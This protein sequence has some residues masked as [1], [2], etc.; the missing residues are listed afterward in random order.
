MTVRV[1]R[2]FEFPV[3]PERVWEFIADPELRAR[4]ISVV[5][6]FELDDE[7]GKRATWY[8]ELPIPL[9]N[10]TVPVQT[11]D[12]ERREPEF[13]KF[14]GR[15]R[16]MKVTGEHEIVPTEEGC[17]LTN[18][19]VVDGKLPGVERYFKRHLDEEL[20]NLEAAMR[21]YLDLPA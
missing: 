7:T 9:L 6:R 19:F 14:T 1:E 17:R 13:V 15:S 16:V 10:K 4:S 8:V 18:L 5:S 21:E 20:D 11:R 3:R 12:V 2:T